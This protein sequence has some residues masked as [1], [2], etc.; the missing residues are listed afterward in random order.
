MAESVAS[1]KFSSGSASALGFYWRPSINDAPNDLRYRKGARWL[2]RA[3]ASVDEPELPKAAAGVETWFFNRKLATFLSPLVCHV[4]KAKMPG[5]FAALRT[6]LASGYVLLLEAP[7]DF[8]LG[9]HGSAPE[10]VRALLAPF[11]ASVGRDTPVAIICGSADEVARWRDCFKRKKP[12]VV[13]VVDRLDCQRDEVPWPPWCVDSGPKA[14][15]ACVSAWYVLLKELV[16]GELLDDGDNAPVQPVD[17][18]DV[19]AQEARKEKR[20]PTVLSARACM[21]VCVLCMSCGR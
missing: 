16:G 10:Q 2:L 9:A 12:R 1:S 3:D 14:V 18:D 11:V 8:N 13:K 4:D 15:A 19:A 6:L 20:P 21:C 7:G 17:E 5:R